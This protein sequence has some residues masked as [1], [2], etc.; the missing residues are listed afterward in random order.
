MKL[1]GIAVAFAMAA[2]LFTAPAAHAQLSGATPK[3][4]D[5]QQEAL[6][7]ALEEQ[8]RQ[9]AELEALQNQLEE[10]IAELA[11]RE[12]LERIRPDLDGFQVMAYLGLPGGP[13]IKKALDHL[14]EIRLDEGPLD[15]EEA[16]ARL[17]AWAR[18]EGIEPAG[19]KAPPR[20]KKAPVASASGPKEKP[21]SG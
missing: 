14:L 13:V 2:A 18:S 8:Q 21:T 7:K 9:I 11:A 5:E 3:L 20:E 17:E 15:Q 1:R 10:R 16:Y 19:E 6:A 12:E 4:T